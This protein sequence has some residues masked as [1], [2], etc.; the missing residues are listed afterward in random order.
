LK[1]APAMP[2][3]RRDD[4][5]Q[6]DAWFGLTRQMSGH[7]IENDRLRFQK[8]QK[9]L[10]TSFAT[11]ARLLEPAEGDAEIS[12]EGIVS[13]GPRAELARSGVRALDVI[14][15]HRGVQTIDRVIRDIN[16]IG[17]IVG[18]DHAQHRPENLLPRDGRMVVH[19]AKH[20]GLNEVAAV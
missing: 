13:N 19:V 18:R 11:D 15:E 16:R 2:G 3:R 12:A 1:Q 4:V 17:F 9:A 10:R 8:R 5:A 7:G 20:S 14:R 6:L